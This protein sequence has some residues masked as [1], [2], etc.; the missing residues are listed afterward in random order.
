MRH[1]VVEQ[2]TEAWMNLRAGIPT[3]SQFSNIITAKTAQLSKSSDKYLAWLAAERILGRPLDQPYT[4]PMQHGKDFEAK[5]VAAYDFSV[6]IAS[7]PCG[8]VTN[9]A[10]TIG[11]SPDRFVGEEGLL[12]IKCPQE[13]TYMTYL[14]GFASPTDDDYRAQIQ[15]QLWVCERQW[16]DFMPF[17]PELPPMDP[18][19]PLST[20][21]PVTTAGVGLPT[22]LEYSSTIQ[23]IT[24]PFV[25]TSGA[26]TSFSGPMIGA[27]LRVNS[28]VSRSSS[29]VESF[30]GSTAT[31]PLP[32]PYGTS[33]TAFFIVIQNARAF[34]SSISTAG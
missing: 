13:V 17:H 14:L 18:E 19:P 24:V 4:M 34:A 27:S 28:R 21:F 3:A 32:P 23:L 22:I 9:D 6:G 31:P 30:F 15:G 16:V 2:G 11:A 25:F 7:T 33:M 8:F 12:E 1:H 5:A 26:G 20:G 29:P 10:C